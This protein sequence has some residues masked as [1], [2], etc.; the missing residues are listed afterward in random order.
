M[1]DRPVSKYY[2]DVVIPD[3]MRRNFDVYE[4]IDKLGI[5]LGSFEEDVV[6]LAGAGIAGAVIQESGLVFLSGTTSGTYPMNDDAAR[7]EHGREAAQRAADVHIRRL[8]WALS[9]GG[10][11]DLNDVL[12]TVKALGM[13]VSSGG[14]VSS[15][16]PAVTNGYSFRWHSVFGGGHSDYAI[17]G[18]DPGGFSGVHARSAIGGF[19]GRFSIEPELIVAIPAALA[20]AIIRNR[21]WLFP[22]PPAMLD[23]VRAM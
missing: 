14:G 18:V 2:D 12:Y 11:G 21:G 13:V 22:L 3:E 6:S 10:E 5:A 19:D 15:A 9:C 8:H 4:R 16:A 1:E 7:I 17:D 20:Q 23:K